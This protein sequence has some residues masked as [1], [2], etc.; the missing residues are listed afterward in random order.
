[1]VAGL[2]VWL[3]DRGSP[4]YISFRVGRDGVPFRLV[5]LRSM[6]I[7]AGHSGVDTTTTSDRR[8]TPVGR[9][10]RR[11][12]LDEVP[13]LWNVL[14]GDM[15]LVGPR[16][17]VPREVDRYTATERVQLSLRPGLTDL[18]SIVFSNLGEILANSTDPNGDYASSIRPWKS[19]LG[20]L[21]LRER[22]VRLDVEIVALTLTC[23]ISRR[24]SLRGIEA[25]LARLDAPGDVCRMVRDLRDGVAPAQILPPGTDPTSAQLAGL[26]GGK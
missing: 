11:S 14:V 26:H 13:Q 15:S 6:V 7:G 19:R 23:L 4:L 1:M 3:Q 16:P 20:L 12:K 9:I 5:K 22:S 18:A 17:N 25:I 2:A 8:I 21:Y 24:T 10:I